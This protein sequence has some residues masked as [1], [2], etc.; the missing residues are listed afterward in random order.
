MRHVLTAALIITGVIHILPLAGVLGPERLLSLYGVALT[1]P[2]LV[3]LMRH[4]AV[5]FGIL[6]T[7][8]LAS[9]FVPKLQLSALL[10]GYASVVS[11]LALAAMTGSYNSAIVRIVTADWVALGA[12]VLATVAYALARR[13]T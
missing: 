12:L 3:L 8:F 5:L 7:F 10:A 13:R 11:F 6:G 1:D 4:R 2:S 9:A